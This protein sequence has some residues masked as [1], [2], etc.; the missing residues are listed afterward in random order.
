MLIPFL[1]HHIKF[2]SL[3][4]ILL[5]SSVTCYLG[6]FFTNVILVFSFLVHAKSCLAP[7]VQS[8]Y[9]SLVQKAVLLL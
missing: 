1:L 9:Y 6:R 3:H 8:L 5:Q 7:K 4:S 2:C